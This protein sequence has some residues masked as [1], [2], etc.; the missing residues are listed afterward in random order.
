MFLP[1]GFT[2]SKHRTRAAK[3]I[4]RQVKCLDSWILWIISAWHSF[5]LFPFVGSFFLFLSPIASSYKHVTRND[6]LPLQLFIPSAVGMQAN[7]YKS[8]CCWFAGVD[9]PFWL[10]LC[11]FSNDPV[12]W[13]REWAPVEMNQSEQRLLYFLLLFWTHYLSS[14]IWRLAGH[15][16]KDR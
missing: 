9:L 3:K 6:V 13:D 7:R 2:S 8:S 5:P 15:R 4:K 16:L 14:K 10:L 12:P 1:R 11:F